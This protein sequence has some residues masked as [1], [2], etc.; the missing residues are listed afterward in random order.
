MK[1][2][3]INT[4]KNWRGLD[5]HEYA[6]LIEFG[7]GI[8]L[9]SLASHIQK[10]GYDELEPIVLYDRK[11]LMG[12][13]RHTAAVNAEVTPSFAEFDGT[14]AEAL[15]YVRKDIIRRHLDAS[16]R[17]MI[18]ASLATLLAG[19]TKKALENSK[20]QSPGGQICPPD[21][22]TTAEAA[23][24]MNVSERS[25]KH[26]KLVETKGCESL[27]RAVVSGTHSVSDA[28]SIAHL[29]PG[30]QEEAMRNVRIGVAK[31]LAEAAG[32][33]KKKPK[34]ETPPEEKPNPV[35]KVE[36]DSE[37]HVLTK[38]SAD[39]FKSVKRFD[40]IDKLI[41]QLQA[42]ISD[43]A[44]LS[45]GEQLRRCLKPTGDDAKVSFRSEHLNSLKRDLKGTR[46]YSV[47][48]YCVGKGTKDCKGCQGSAWVTKVTWDHTEEQTKGKLS[49]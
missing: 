47:C 36:T 14:D 34:A 46:P 33:K 49:C 19:Q 16:Q 24:T 2:R 29:E 23:A 21:A 31:T 43:L 10:N 25:V 3:K 7:V 8:D 17:A 15:E 6:N 38:A 28:A 35:P 41:R 48:P 30:Q 39:A 32:V 45:G 22:T 42:E 9:D 11:I 4:P 1:L 40:S 18:A 20:S 13:H 37:G 26:A 44:Q 5:T 12:R 27:Q